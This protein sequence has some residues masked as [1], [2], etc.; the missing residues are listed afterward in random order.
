MV[1]KP[2]VCDTWRGLHDRGCGM[3]CSWGRHPG[4]CGVVVVE[5]VVSARP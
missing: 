3:R 4:R 2:V 1:A 5:L